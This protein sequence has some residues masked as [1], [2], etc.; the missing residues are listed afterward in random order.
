MRQLIFPP[1]NEAITPTEKNLEAWLPIKEA[2]DNLGQRKAMATNLWSANSRPP[3]RQFSVM[4]TCLTKPL[5]D[6]PSLAS[7]IRKN[8]RGLDRKPACWGEQGEGTNW[9][10][11]M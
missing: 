7:R 6:Q 1:N 10:L 5:C 3:S 4:S 2:D 9:T 11:W 8:A